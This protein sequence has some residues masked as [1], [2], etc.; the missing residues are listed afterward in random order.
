MPGWISPWEIA[1]V[2]LVALLLF[3]GKRLPE[4]GRSLGTGMREFKNSISGKDETP[5]QTYDELPP[6]PAQQD[7]AVAPAREHDT[8]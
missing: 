2:L 6:P 8:V 7:P 4:M 5:A 3:G 1:L